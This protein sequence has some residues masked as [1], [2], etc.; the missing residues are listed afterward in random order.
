MTPY[1]TMAE[2]EGFEQ[3]VK[4]LGSSRIIFHLFSMSLCLCASVVSFVV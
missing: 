3:N 2:R 4:C 1:N